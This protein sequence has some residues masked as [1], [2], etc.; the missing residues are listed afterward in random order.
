[1]LQ[2]ERALFAAFIYDCIVVV[3]CFIVAVQ[4]GSLTILGEVAR[5]SKAVVDDIGAALPESR[6]TVTPVLPD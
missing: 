5:I 1:M 2:R 3:P 6:V 4:S